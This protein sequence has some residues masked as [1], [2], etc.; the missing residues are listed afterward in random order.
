MPVPDEARQGGTPD[1]Y[2]ELQV[3]RDATLEVIQA[4]YR[5]LARRHHPDHSDDPGASARMAAINAAWRIIGDPSRR[6]DYDRSS[7]LGSVGGSTSAPASASKAPAQGSGLPQRPGV[8]QW[9][10]GPDGEG[11]AGPPP[12]RPSGSVLGFGR[13]IGWSLGEIARVD[14]GY[15]NWLEQTPRGKRYRDE[16]EVILR[17]TGNRADRAGN[18]QPARRGRFS[19]GG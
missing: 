1:P 13:H 6:A 19:R 16:I 2:A 11:A 15:L 3:N 17:Q 7:R 18:A 9:H 4:A 5:S 12:G 14:P 8:P 10:T